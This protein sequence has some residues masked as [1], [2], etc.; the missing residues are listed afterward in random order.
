MQSPTILPMKHRY[1]L[2][3]GFILE[4]Y[5]KNTNIAEI[6]LIGNICN[7]LLILQ[8]YCLF[9]GNI[10]NELLILQKYMALEWKYCQKKGKTILANTGAL[11]SKFEQPM[12]EKYFMSILVKIIHNTN[13]INLLLGN[14]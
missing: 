12:L 7:E 10:C 2:N 6:L 4:E 5:A 9:T 1:W 3:F 14:S 8:K 13:N 11:L